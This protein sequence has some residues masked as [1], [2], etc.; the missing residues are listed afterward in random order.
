MASSTLSPNSDIEAQM[1]N[2]P[3]TQPSIIINPPPTTDIAAPQLRSNAEPQH[4]ATNIDQ[5]LTGLLARI[6]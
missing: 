6:C 3:E 1:N 5:H 4:Q 2:V